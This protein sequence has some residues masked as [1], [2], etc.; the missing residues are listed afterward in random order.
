M[1]K[2]FT[3]LF[4]I[5]CFLAGAADLYVMPG[6]PAPYYSSISSA[7][8]AASDGDRIIVAPGSY[9]GN[10]TINQG[11]SIIPLSSGGTYTI[12]GTVQIDGNTSSSGS[13]QGGGNNY[14]VRCWCIHSNL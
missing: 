5:S 4:T 3:L 9:V 12:V 13:G 2:L 8:T 11:L 14:T 1:K 7:V 10:I 6:A